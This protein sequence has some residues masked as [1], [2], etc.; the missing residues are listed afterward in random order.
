MVIDLKAIVESPNMVLRLEGHQGR[1]QSLAFLPDGRRIVSG[2]ADHTVRIWN[3][4][5]GQTIVGPLA[6]HRSGI[7]SLAVSPDGRFIASGSYDGTV[8]IWD[9]T[10]EWTRWDI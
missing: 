4:E 9:L 1:V 6:G 7:P 3:L 8:R 2:S 10:D 5:T